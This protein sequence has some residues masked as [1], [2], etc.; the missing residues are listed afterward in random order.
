M[1][2]CR[3]SAF[4]RP[5]LGL[6]GFMILLTFYKL[7]TNNEETEIDKGYTLN[8]VAK[9]NALPKTNQVGFKE[10]LHW[11]GRNRP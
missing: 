8:Y 1:P 7:A 11:R 6:T 4:T 3:P 2:A 5:I 9:M 10:S